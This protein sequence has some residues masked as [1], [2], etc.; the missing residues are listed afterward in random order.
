MHSIRSAK[1][2][3]AKDWKSGHEISIKTAISNAFKLEYDHIFPQA[4]LKPFLEKKYDRS[5][6]K[7]LVNDIGNICFLQ[8]VTNIQKSDKLPEERL[9][10]V[11]DD[12]GEEALSA[13]NITLDKSLWSLEMYEEFLK[14][15]R[16]KIA[17]GI[18]NLMNSLGS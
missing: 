7:S 14:D 6:A 13:Q 2:N 1:N 16:Q 5:K 9:P 3:H 12:W 10:K 11:V 18:N 4:Q 8:K 15:R 17:D